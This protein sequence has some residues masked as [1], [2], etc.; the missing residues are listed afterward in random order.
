[1]VSLVATPACYV[2]IYPFEGG[3]Y[4]LSGDN[5]NLL[6]LTTSKNIRTGQGTFNMTLAPG[7]PY[8]PNARPGWLEILTP[9]SLVVI[10]HARAGR[11]AVTMIGVVKTIN[12]TE[13]W[14]PGQGVRR[15]RIPSFF[16]TI[17]SANTVR[18]PTAC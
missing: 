12:T 18:F 13:A 3:A 6:S 11:A 16:P 2:D 10:G 9:M 14:V 7:G 8:G 15:S 5:A 4:T 1:M 17:S